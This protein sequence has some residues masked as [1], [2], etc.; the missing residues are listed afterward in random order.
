MARQSLFLRSRVL[1]GAILCPSLRGGFRNA[2]RAFRV[3]FGERIFLRTETLG[4]S[5]ELEAWGRVRSPSSLQKLK[6]VPLT[7]PATPGRPWTRN[8]RLSR[9]DIRSRS[10]TP[11]PRSRET[12]AVGSLNKTILA[13][14][15]STNANAGKRRQREFPCSTS[16]GGSGG[17]IFLHVLREFSEAK[18]ERLSELFYFFASIHL[19]HKIKIYRIRLPRFPTL[20]RGRCRA[21][22]SCTSPGMSLF[23]GARQKPS[24]FA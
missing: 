13:A 6:T 11:G 2:V 5:L 16:A 20:S 3:E 4:L 21:L 8:P 23:L 14:D 18:V 7:W 24:L 22:N 12:A 19:C 1:G 17:G 10:V 9:T 15:A